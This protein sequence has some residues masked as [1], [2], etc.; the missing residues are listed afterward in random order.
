[1]DKYLNIAIGFLAFI[2]IYLGISFLAM[3]V[4]RHAFF[5]SDID[6][7]NLSLVTIG[8]LNIMAIPVISE[9]LG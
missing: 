3:T 7:R 9:H 2:V 6:A 4:L 5:F 1:M 8:I